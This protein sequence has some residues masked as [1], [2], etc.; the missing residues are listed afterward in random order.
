MRYFC[1]ALIFFSCTGLFSQ[2]DSVC[3]TCTK[4]PECPLNTEAFL[5]HP[6]KNHKLAP[7][8][9]NGDVDLKPKGSPTTIFVRDATGKIVFG[10]VLAE[11]EHRISLKGQPKG[12]YFVEI[13]TEDIKETVKMVVE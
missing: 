13:I 6:V 1:F 5:K 12:V 4:P 8:S 7:D 3:R 10:K 11:N 9:L 2:N